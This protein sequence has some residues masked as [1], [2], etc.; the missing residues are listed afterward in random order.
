[1]KIKYLLIAL[2]FLF[3]C[4]T[5]PEPNLKVYTINQGAHY[6]NG[7]KFKLHSNL[8]QLNFKAQLHSD[9]L[10]QLG[11]EDDFDINKV[12]GITWG[13]TNDNNSFRIGWNCQNNNGLIQYFSYAHIGGEVVIQYLFEEVPE[14]IINFHIDLLRSEN[15]I[16]IYRLDNDTQYEQPYPFD[17]IS[18]TGYYNYP[19]FGGNQ[20]APHKMTFGIE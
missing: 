9:C 6:S 11:N 3:S 16:R 14:V 15:L 19:Y 20:F 4:S 13:L 10:F 5:P 2:A 8:H 18:A 17:G 12:Y 1:M 7:P